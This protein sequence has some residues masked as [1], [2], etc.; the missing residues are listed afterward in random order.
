MPDTWAKQQPSGE[1]S[2][3]LSQITTKRFFMVEAHHRSIKNSKKQDWYAGEDYIVGSC[4]DTIH[5]RLPA[6][7][8]VE[9]IVEK[10]EAKDDVLVE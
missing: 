9:L 7:A 6:E 8:I 1:Q 2:R 3:I 5:Q 4:T 10:K